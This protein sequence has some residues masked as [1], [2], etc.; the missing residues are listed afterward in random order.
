[1]FPPQLQTLG[2]EGGKE[3]SPAIPSSSTKAG[4]GL[5]FAP[6]D[7]RAWCREGNPHGSWLCN[8]Q[9]TFFQPK[10]LS[11]QM[12]RLI[13]PSPHCFYRLMLIKLLRKPA[14]AVEP[15]APSTHRMVHRAEISLTSRRA[16]EIEALPPHSLSLT[17]SRTN[18]QKQPLPGAAG[19]E[20][21]GGGLLLDVK[22][23]IF[24]AEVKGEEEGL[25]WKSKGLS[26]GSWG[27]SALVLWAEIPSPCRRIS[28]PPSRYQ[29]VVGGLSLR[30]VQCLQT[31]QPAS[32]QAGKVQGGR[33][34]KL[35]RPLPAGWVT[36]E[37]R[38]FGIGC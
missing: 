7:S 13:P 25:Y 17:D 4:W 5:R 20:G 31:L 11:E 37:S 36:T 33:W 14:N 19:E 9:P 22:G 23:Q 3:G 32:Q 29:P 30:G 26:S 35:L 10:H 8:P 18:L 15:A 34:G 16:A 21:A 6:C 24:T 2:D 12:N 1:M 28:V 38:Q 27:G